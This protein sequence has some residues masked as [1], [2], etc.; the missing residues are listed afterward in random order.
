MLDIIDTKRSLII[1]EKEPSRGP[2]ICV[3]GTKQMVAILWFH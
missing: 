3:V 2:S 1:N